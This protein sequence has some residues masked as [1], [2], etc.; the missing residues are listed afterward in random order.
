MG[1]K[2]VNDTKTDRP[3]DRRSQ[4]QSNSIQMFACGAP[5]TSAPVR[6]H[7]CSV[8]VNSHIVFPL[9]DFSLHVGCT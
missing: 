2:G 4:H 9:V 6:L 5:V 8:L 1:P 7:V 3:T